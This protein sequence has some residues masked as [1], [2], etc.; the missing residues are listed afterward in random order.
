MHQYR[1]A[2]VLFVLLGGLFMGLVN[3]ENVRKLR[4]TAGTRLRDLCPVGHAN[5]S[6]PV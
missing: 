2:D 3:G 4:Q 6:G 1:F 5:V